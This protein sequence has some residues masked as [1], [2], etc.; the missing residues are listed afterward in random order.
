MLYTQFE[1][2]IKIPLLG[3]GTFRAA[4]DECEAAVLTALETGYRLIDTA[5][6]YRN[7][8]FV[9]KAIAKSGIPREELFITTKVSFK[10]FEHARKSVEASLE[11]MG[12]DY[13]DLVL[14][15]WPFANVYAAWR[16]LE[17]LYEE[18]VLRSIGV[19][20][21]EPYR[22]VDIIGYNKIK[23]AINQIETHLYCQRHDEHVWEKKYGVTHQSYSPLG[24]AKANEMFSEPDVVATAQKYGKTP[25]QVLLRFL[26]QNEVVVIPKSVHPG[27]I[28]ENFDL[29]DF[30]LD[31]KDMAALKA[32][33]RKSPFTG[34]PTDPNKVESAMAW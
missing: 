26:I 16:D 20:N 21:F 7:E 14:L 12:L 29:F 23:P 32:L 22:L 15:H 24:Q 28:R 9:G 18:G 8:E 1:N 11:K 19:S 25:A 4:G 31:E 10:S 34:V 33:D 30:E 6:A 2:G 17:K 13:L 5:E 3:F 27:R